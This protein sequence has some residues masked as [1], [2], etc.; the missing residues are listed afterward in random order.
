MNKECSNRMGTNL[1]GDS[2]NV[3]ICD[4]V[5]KAM[6]KSFTPTKIKGVFRVTG[7]YPFNE[8]IFRRNCLENLGSVTEENNTL[9]TVEEKVMITLKDM[10]KQEDSKRD[11]KKRVRATIG[12]NQAYTAGHVIQMH[13]EE[14]RRKEEEASEKRAR[15]EASEEKKKDIQKKKA[16]KKLALAMKSRAASIQKAE[17]MREIRAKSCTKCRKKKTIRTKDAADWFRCQNCM[18][19]TLCPNH[20]ADK[21]IHLETCKK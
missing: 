4:I 16:A 20:A 14:V 18:D 6:E 19:F 2:L 13:Q 8:E 17:K 12:L 9:S 5:P 11:G 3:M 21:E 7:L 10:Y 1:S 15:T